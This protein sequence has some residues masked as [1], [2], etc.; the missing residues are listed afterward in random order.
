MDLNTI[1]EKVYREYVRNGYKKMWNK[2]K[3]IKTQKIRDIAELGLVTTEVSEAIEEIRNH[4]TNIDNL[5]FECA[6][7]IIRTLNFMTRKG[8]N[9]NNYIINKSK[10]NLL[11]KKLHNRD[12]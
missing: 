8:L 2:S 3:C 12:V 7:I 9:A 4:N 5:G 10:K 6:D 1:Q 11:R